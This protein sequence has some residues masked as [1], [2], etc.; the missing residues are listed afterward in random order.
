MILNDDTEREEK[1][2]RQPERGKRQAKSRYL[3]NIKLKLDRYP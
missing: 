2:R 1:M 3:H